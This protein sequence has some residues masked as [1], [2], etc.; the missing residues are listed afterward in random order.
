[1][2]EPLGVAA[3]EVGVQFLIAVRDMR[4]SR[5]IS[6]GE[7]GSLAN[8]IGPLPARCRIVRIAV[9]IVRLSGLA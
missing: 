9:V 4:W 1:M 3:D 5:D 8:S 6:F 7:R 2:R